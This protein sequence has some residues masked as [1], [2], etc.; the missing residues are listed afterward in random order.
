M[1][2]AA[3]AI[4]S[5]QGQWPAAWLQP[6]APAQRPGWVY[7]VVVA[8]LAATNQPLRPRDIIQLATRFHGDPIAPSSVRNCLRMVSARNDGAIERVSYGMYRLRSTHL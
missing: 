8:A 1:R 4:A 7:E 5:D 2:K 6:A 3:K